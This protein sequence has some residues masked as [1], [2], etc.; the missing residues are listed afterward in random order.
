[1]IDNLLTIL[2]ESAEASFIEVTVFVGAVLLLFG[3]ID[4]LQS[5]AFVEAIERS[6]RYQPLIGALLGIIPGCG[7]S[8]LLVTLYIKDTVTFGT[9]VAT[10]VAT[11]GDAAFVILTQA[12]RLFLLITFYCFLAG[13]AAGYLVDYLKIGD[14]VKK[15]RA[16]KEAADLKEE[17]KEV[18][19]ALDEL[20]CDNPVSCRSR[21]LRHVGHEEGD[22]IDLALHHAT[23]LDPGSLG[24]RIT[25]NAYFVFWGFIAV[26]LVLGVLDL[27]QVDI[28]RLPGIPNLG[29]IIGVVGTVV[30]ILYTIL[31]RRFLQAQSHEDAEHKLFSLEETFIHNAQETAFVGAW[32]FAAYV[33][34]ELAV[35]VTGGEQVLLDAMTSTGLAAVLLGTLVGA[36]P[37]CGPQVIFVSLYLKGVFPFA[38]MLANSIS[39]D[40]DAL[41]PLIAMDRRAA[42]WATVV[43]TIVAV[44]VGLLTYFIEAGLG[45]V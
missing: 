3:Y 41:F 24:Y 11:A 31:S 5:G 1:M 43:T 26:G 19:A 20:Y 12:P 7:G 40:G 27:M 4:Y 32:V 18:E 23:P 45:L 39:Q 44:I 29:I 22:E 35:L 17:H 34:Y 6:K 9:V 8:I 33:A 25:H 10:L 2:L 13:V 37:G 36:I 15:R 16:V 28:N 38:A 42:F 30:T 14:F 21:Q